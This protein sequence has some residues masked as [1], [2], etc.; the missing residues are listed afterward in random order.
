MQVANLMTAGPVTIGPRDKLS[1]AKASMVAGKFRRL[2]VVEGG[3]LVA[4]LTE[5]DIREHGGYLDTTRVSAGMRSPVLT[6]SPADTVEKAARL[7]LK[8]KI[9][10]LPVVDG[11]R[12][13][14]IVTASDLLK[15]F[16]SVVEG[17]QKILDD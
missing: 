5:R 2:P 15:A 1:D 17:A 7:M 9:G 10:G 11:D 8:H 13:V 6:V 3:K 4:M 14:G 12:V 16:L